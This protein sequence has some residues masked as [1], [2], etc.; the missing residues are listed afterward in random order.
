M[1]AP[2]TTIMSILHHPLLLY[3]VNASGYTAP[4]EA[5]ELVVITRE[6]L[7]YN[8]SRELEGTWAYQ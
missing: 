7:N 6:F 5:I 2:R 4:R 1:L 8:G 3:Q